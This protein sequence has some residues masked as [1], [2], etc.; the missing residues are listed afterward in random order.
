MAI[1]EFMVNSERSWLLIWGCFKDMEC[2]LGRRTMMNGR[3][4]KRD[5]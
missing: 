5:I 1:G 4:V 2:M 3:I